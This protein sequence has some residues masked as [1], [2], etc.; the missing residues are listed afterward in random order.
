M[1]TYLVVDKLTMPPGLYG[2]NVTRGDLEELRLK[3][4]LRVGE[5]FLMIMFPVVW[6][7]WKLFL[8]RVG[9]ATA[10]FTKIPMLPIRGNEEPWLKEAIIIPGELFKGHYELFNKKVFDG[11]FPG[12]AQLEEIL[13]SN[14]LAELIILG[15]DGY[16]RSFPSS[17]RN[18]NGLCIQDR[19][20]GE[21]IPIHNYSLR[22]WDLLGVL[23]RQC[24]G[25]L[26]AT[27]ITLLDKSKRDMSAQAEVKKLTARAIKFGANAEITH[28]FDIKETWGVPQ[29][30]P[31]RVRRSVEM[32]SDFPH[33]HQK[34]LQQLELRRSGTFTFKE[35]IDLSFGVSL[36]FLAAFQGVL[37]GGYQREFSVSIVF[38]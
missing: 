9:T 11:V 2:I 20:S 16:I 27:E 3:G 7:F 12:P 25:W 10:E 8:P 15:Y 37:K 35:T 19:L 29:W 1:T 34:A 22:K 18:I 4:V 14:K 28:S 5:F 21:L 17:P 23:I 36:E 31:E 38:G 30:E 33:I 13:P 6:F 24:F 32:L 26:G